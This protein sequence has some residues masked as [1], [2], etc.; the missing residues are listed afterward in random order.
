MKTSRYVLTACALILSVEAFGQT[1]E[2]SASV[3]KLQ[4]L[5]VPVQT[6]SKSYE[7]S[8]SF[9]EP[10]VIHYSYD[11]T[12]QKGNKV[13]YAY[14]FNLSDIDPYAVR[15][16]TQKDIISV[17]L[18]VRNKQKLVK[19]YKD[20]E[21]QPYDDQVSILSKDIENARAISEAVKKAIGPAEKIMA[22]RLKL[23][24]Y[25]ATLAWLT[26]NIGNVELGTTTYK[27][28][29]AK[30]DRIGSMQLTQ[31]EAN[32]KTAAEDV[33]TF[34]LAD[35]NVNS[36]NYKITGNKF[37]IRFETVQNAKY[38]A[39]RR[40]G[41]VRPYVD[42]LTIV[43]NNVDE[44]R[45]L[46][47]VLALA[48]GLAEEKVKADM[49][50]IASEK[51]ALQQLKSL[52]REI[53]TGSKQIGQEFEA[54]CS[55][56]LT[57]VEKDAKSS[58]K[59]FY[60]FNWI[61]VNPAANKINVTG[62]RLFITVAMNDGKKLI[63]LSVD[64]KFSGYENDLKL[65]MP[66]IETA[67][68]AR[69]ALDKAVEKCKSSY[70]EPFGGDA[71]S[72]TSWIIGN[73]NDVILDDVTVKQTLETA[74]AGQHNKLKYTQRELNSKGSGA[75]E[76]Y[77]LN[78]SDINPLSIELEVKGKWLYVVMETDFKGKII[79]YYK[80]GKIQPYASRLAFAINDVDAS[81]SM[82]SALKKAVNALKPK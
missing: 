25:D 7:P 17:V 36:I 69:F 67:R 19:V 2:L 41:E 5:V 55:C 16:Q 8:V 37:A 45:D 56:S 18:A 70:K 13:R 81:R 53:T 43:T 15:E 30:S 29:L 39:A 80:D 76:V 60:K 57:Q 33:Y 20:E 68:R 40:N 1:G 66:D 61:D 14:E 62:D 24:G 23:S 27:Q 21:V 71:A 64:D 32:G 3:T 35:I 82:V 52:T 34:N 9:H 42:D 50:A 78:L 65:Y 22:E 28:S 47:T 26:G 4:Q 72:L 38:I 77:E 58:K 48:A 59:Y 54:Q 31:T 44:A 79:K 11:E 10:A 75:E 6:A 46:K 51:D 12:D 74:E 63:M 49:P 73:V